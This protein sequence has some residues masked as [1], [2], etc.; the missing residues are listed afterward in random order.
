MNLEMREDELR[1]LKSNIQILHEQ[2]EMLSILCSKGASALVIGDSAAAI[3]YPD[4]LTREL[5]EIDL[6]LQ[7]GFIKGIASCCAQNG[8]T[9]FDLPEDQG[10]CVHLMK[11]GFTIHLFSEIK[12]FDDKTKNDLLNGWIATE[13]SIDAS[14]GNYTIPTTPYWIN[15]LLQLALLQRDA[16]IHRIHKQNL[17]DWM[18]FVKSYL[19]DA[20]WST[21]GVKA[22]Q[23]GLKEFAKSITR[24]GKQYFDVDTP[25]CDSAEALDGVFVVDIQKESGDNVASDHTGS[26]GWLKKILRIV[27]RFIKRSF[28]CNTFYYLND[29]YFVIA[30]KMQGESHI[31]PEEIEAVEEN[32]TFIFKSFNRQR[33]AKRL[34]YNI[35]GYYP[36]AEVIIAD[37]SAIPL[38]IPGVIHLPFNSG[39]SKGLQAALDAVETPYVVRF[40]DDM[41]LTAK[42][43][44]HEELKFLE[45]HPEVDLV[46]IMAD[47]KRPR[48]YAEKFSS[49]RMHK[50]LII[51]AGTVIDG[52]EVV[53]KTPNC[54]IARTE[55]L[56]L[57]GYDENIHIFDH[58]E[59]FSRAA[60]RIVCVIDPDSCIMHC[61]NMFEKQNYESFRFDTRNDIQYLRGKHVSR[62]QRK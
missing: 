18:M 19:N 1:I 8:Y 14:I 57:V 32:V 13:E 4:P 25:W 44:I 16:C 48:E 51:P 43:N 59:F 28:L 12:L 20:N 21:F 45:E 37:D 55:K 24:Y 15:G 9:L 7:K 2:K 10:N 52:K 38:E 29:L 61:H 60:G 27:Y 36:K 6:V 26:D 54:F 34:Y 3:S 39:L 53:Y 40:D 23:L 11:N 17:N 31:K 33:Q 56:R 5:R 30:T 46:A 41:L 42:S 35:K 62:Y 49:I 58:H 22:E 47:Y 50:N